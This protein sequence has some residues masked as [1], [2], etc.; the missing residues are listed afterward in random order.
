M[1]L[2]D[3]PKVCVGH[4]YP[5]HTHDG[6]RIRDFYS[7]RPARTRL[8]K[9]LP[10]AVY[11]RTVGRSMDSS[12]RIDDAFAAFFA[13]HNVDLI[14]AEFGPSGSGITRHAKSL[15]IPLIVH[16]H[17]HD[18][19][20]TSVVNEHRA[21][22]REMFDYAYRIVSVSRYMTEALVKLGADR[23]K[24]LYNPYGPRDSFFDVQPDYRPT[25]LSVGRFTD[26]K[27]NYLTLAAFRIALDSVPGARLNMVGEGELRESCRTLA[28]LWEI[29]GSVDFPG[30]VNHS[31][32]A[33]QYS[34]AC[35]FAQHSISPSYGDA[36]GTPVA[37]LEA[38]AAAL[39]VVATR[40]AGIP[41]VVV[42]EV[43]GFLVKEGDVTAMAEKMKTLLQD[44]KLCR[45]MGSAAR[46][47]VRKNY[48]M[49]RHISTLQEA[50]NSA[51]R[52]ALRDKQTRTRT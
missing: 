29:D 28:R 38:G 5:D 14:L 11:S 15:G 7:T 20:R 47:H 30:A 33:Q 32:V 24:I 13:E 39:P 6:K 1:E 12:E 18:A 25:V 19:H 42:D 27:A 36:E 52:E 50:M 45:Q 40:H 37:I 35:C 10:Q 48:S 8:G 43:T 44:P 41:D 17:G 23:A 21:G 26:I 4:W 22:Y 16:F 9:L 34:Q 46:E 2:L 31:D 3:G 49:G 51:R